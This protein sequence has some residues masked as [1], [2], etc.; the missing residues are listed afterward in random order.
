MDKNWI[1]VR[2]VNKSDRAIELMVEPWGTSEM[3]A[4]E[5][6]FAIRYTP[7]EHRDDTSHAEVYDDMIRFWVEG[8][9]Y[10]IE[11]DGV[12]LDC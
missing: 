11:V 10:E 5:A 6:P 2:F 7:P 1:T 8:D 9:T 4:P 3:I 12:R